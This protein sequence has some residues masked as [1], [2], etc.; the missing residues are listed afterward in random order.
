L[1][2]DALGMLFDKL[3]TNRWEFVKTTAATSRREFYVSAPEHVFAYWKEQWSYFSCYRNLFM[4]LFPG[5]VVW[6]C[7]AWREFG[8]FSG[9]IVLV[10]LILVGIALWYTMRDILKI[11]Y[12]ISKQFCTSTGK[13]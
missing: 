7:S 13:S 5:S 9:L 10:I 1:I 8:F 4:L 2:V 11:Y 3:V 12:K 6:T